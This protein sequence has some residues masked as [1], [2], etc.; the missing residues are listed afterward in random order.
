MILFL[1]D[2]KKY[3]SAI[4]DTTTKNE[5]FI[6]LARLYKSMGIKNH[7]FILALLQP[8]LQGVDPFDPNLTQEQ[9]IK[10]TME[11]RYNPWYF[12]REVMRAPPISG[13]KPVPFRANRANIAVYWSFFNNIDVADIQPRQTGKSLSVDG[14]MIFILYILANNTLINLITKDDDLRKKNIERLKEIRDLLPK[15]LVVLNSTD[16]N[17]QVELTCNILGNAYSTSVAQNTESAANNLGRGTTAPIL[18][19]D[20]G[21]FTK[22]IGV[23]LPAALA[24]GTEARIQAAANHSPYGNI[25]TTTAGKK[26]D[27]D[28]RYMY[29]LI[30]GGSVWNEIYFDSED[31]EYLLSLLAKNRS[32]RRT[33][34]NITMSH[35]Q[36]G[37]SDKW[38]YDAIVNAGGTEDMVNRDFLNIWTSGTQRSPLSTT[39]NNLIRNSEQEILHTEIS[40]DRYIIRWYIPEEEMEYALEEGFYVA[41]LD[42]SD[43]IGRDTISLVI[44]DIRDL[45]VVGI[46]VFNETNLIRFA[47]FLTWFLT[48]YLKMVLVIERRSSAQSII[49]YLLIKLPQLGIDPFK[50]IF[51]KIVDNHSENPEEFKKILNRPESRSEAFYDVRKSSFGFVTGEKSRDLLYT[52]VLVNAAKKAGHLVKDKTLISEITGL[53]EKNGRIDHTSSGHDDLVIAW[54]MTHWFIGYARNL[55]HYGIEHTKLMS[56]VIEAGKELTDR[57]KEIKEE[58]VRYIEELETLLE[59]LNSVT[60]ELIIA[61]LEHRI[62]VI[63]SRIQSTDEEE[64]F[65]IDSLIQ[66]AA[67]ERA[68]KRRLQSYNQR[69]PDR[70][71]SFRTSLPYFQK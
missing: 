45:S 47:K 32:G 54:L 1:K 6:R 3:P 62:R 7:A 30:T 28:G 26:D 37:Y 55:S 42:T 14:L 23:T 38:L 48:K 36:L 18:H 9:K 11:C 10:I 21:P 4:I 52:T 66:N 43:A 12:F 15:Y 33:L 69:V 2:W 60:D 13:P 20:E 8:E 24:A 63:S 22:W 59:K 25:F 68:K 34:I 53:V 51:N 17:N 61:Q 57:E 49:D 29:D 35:T 56:A 65:S 16:T 58:Q 46:G 40:P 19:S 50:R 44:T 67:I 39:L 27:R 71:G 31:K 70:S 41:G 64:S 5:T